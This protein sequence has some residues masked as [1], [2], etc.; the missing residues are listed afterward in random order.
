MLAAPG[1]Y[2]HVPWCVRKCPYC[3]FNSHEHTGPLPE[4]DYLAAL[5]ADLG[6]EVLRHD[7]LP[8]ASVFFGGGTP[9]LMAPATIGA[10]LER[11]DAL[12]LLAADAEITLEANPGTFDA[13]RFAGYRAAGVN[14]LSIGVQS[15]DD[16]TLH[17]LGRIHDGGA[18]RTAVSAAARLFDTFNVDLMHGSP[19]QNR[20]A[21]VDDLEHALA[22]G[23]PHLSWYQLTIERNTAFWR[24]PPELPDEDT[25]EAIEQAGFDRLAQAGLARYEVS[26]FARPGHASRHNLNYWRFGDYLGIGAGAH[27][28]ITRG[29][30]DV[31]RTRRTRLP[32]DYLAEQRPLDTP[33]AVAE[34]PAEFMLNALRLVDGVPWERFETATGLPLETIAEPVEMLHSRGWLRTDRLA[35]TALG[36]RFLDTVIQAFV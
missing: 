25:L 29:T 7:P 24:S 18:A 34:L 26:A 20:Q 6:A 22:L 1:L 15:F 36:Y 27:G 14:R 33:V 9:S 16:A 5:R 12:G 17:A 19:G 13:A 32:S 11:V 30:A 4:A 2:V 10:V 35:T 3:D 31:L 28:K 23:A 21:A 8:F